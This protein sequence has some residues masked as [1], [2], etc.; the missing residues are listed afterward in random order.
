MHK[1]H[2]ENQEQRDRNQQLEFGF[3]PLKILEL[4]R[5]SQPIT[6]RHIDLVANHLLGLFDII[7]NTDFAFDV[8]KDESH[9]LPVL[10]ANGRRPGLK[11]N[12]RHLGDGNLLPGR[13]GHQYSLQRFHVVAVIPGVAHQDVVALAPLH[14]LRHHSPPHGRHDHPFHIANVE[15]KA[16]RSTSVDGEIQKVPTG[17]ALGKGAAGGIGG[18]LILLQR[19][20]NGD[21]RFFDSGQVRTKHLDAQR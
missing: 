18:A 11:L 17:A 1:E 4:P 10:T 12:V 5:P 13:S 19:F 15:A 20:F 14:G 7:G 3:G 16:S 6:V 21:A 8:H 2:E 9:K